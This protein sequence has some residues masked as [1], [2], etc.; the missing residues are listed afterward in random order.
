MV[1][2]LAPESSSFLLSVLFRSRV[3]LKMRWMTPEMIPGEVASRCLYL[4]AKPSCVG[5]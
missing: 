3:F 5:G 4:V 2:S 1:F